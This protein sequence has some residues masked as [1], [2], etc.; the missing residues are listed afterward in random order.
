MLA[1]SVLLP[2]MQRVC[3]MF[4]NTCMYIY[5]YTQLY[6]LSCSCFSLYM[7]ACF[8]C[9]HRIILKLCSHI[10]V[11]CRCYFIHE[12]SVSNKNDYFMASL[13]IQIYNLLFNTII[14]YSLRILNCYIKYYTII[15][16]VI[17]C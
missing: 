12:F 17:L 16:S 2:Q 6:F 11:L 5:V 9:I 14:D 13:Y 4:W 1:K 7:S 10:Q 8:V 3:N 15:Y